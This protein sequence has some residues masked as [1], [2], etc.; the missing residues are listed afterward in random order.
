MVIDAYPRTCS[1][2][3][4]LLRITRVHLHS[5]AVADSDVDGKLYTVERPTARTVPG[6]LLV[7]EKQTEPKHSLIVIALSGRVACL[8]T[9]S[10]LRR[11]RRRHG[12]TDIEATIT[13]YGDK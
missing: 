2:E 10:H 12:D 4:Q 3:M 8:T 1:L 6:R 7:E 13:L 11:R 9:T 5:S